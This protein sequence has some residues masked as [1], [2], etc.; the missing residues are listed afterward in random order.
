MRAV[1]RS[2]LRLATVSICTTWLVVAV[3]AMSG[4]SVWGQDEELRVISQPPPAKVTVAA[5]TSASEERIRS[6]LQEDTDLEFL[7]T[8]LA[9]VL[10]LVKDLHR[11]P[12]QMDSRALEEAGL[13]SDTPVTRV[14]K[15]IPLRSALNLIL[16]DLG[17]TWV[18]RDDVLMITTQADA[19]R[20]IEVRTYDVSDLT[21]QG[22]A[23]ETLVDAIMTSLAPVEADGSRVRFSEMRRSV[24]PLKNLLIVRDSL[25]GHKNVADLLTAMRQQ[26]APKDAK[27]S[28]GN[29]AT[30]SPQRRPPATTPSRGKAAVPADDPFGAPVNP[31]SPKDEAP[32]DDPAADP[33]G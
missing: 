8:P 23:P 4:R 32:K 7:E 11:I 29:P 25:T 18:I 21:S 10:S 12:V 9:D 30:T 15:G 33:F 17:L 5:T 26:M 20:M 28:A 13:G 24:L 19:A 2:N 16:D 1:V 3:I 6:A 31:F 22:V 14:I 27:S